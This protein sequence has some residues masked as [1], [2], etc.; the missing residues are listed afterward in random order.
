MH[1][2]CLAGAA[3]IIVLGSAPVARSAEGVSVQFNQDVLKS[4]GLD[5]RLAE[6]F[7]QAPRFREGVQAVALSVNGVPK[8]RV[9]VVFDAEGELC[10]TPSLL[11]RGGIRA[12]DYVEP[13]GKAGCE[14]FARHF[15]G[16]VVQADPSQEHISLL[17]PTDALVPDRPA[18]RS[19]LNGGT[20]G[21]FNYD[22]L[23]L[24]SRFAGQSS[25]FRNLNAELGLNAADWS[26]RSR[27]VYSEFAGQDR[28][29][30]L[31]AYAS[32]TSERYRANLQLG[33][34]NM[35]SPLFAGEAFNGVQ[36]Q[37]E[38]ALM[39]L[40]DDSSGARVEGIAYSAAR[41]EVTQNGALIYT[42]VVPG[43]PFTLVG[44]PLLSQS[45][46][47]E[48]TVH[49]EDGQQRRFIVP[50]TQLRGGMTGRAAGYGLAV[51]QVRR[52]AGDE[53]DAPSFLAASKDW[54]LGPRGQVTAGA[55]LG[56]GY[57]SLG[58]AMQGGIGD[59]LI[60][61][62]RQVISRAQDQAVSGTQLQWTASGRLSGRL[63][64]SVALTQ[65]T[66]GFRTL[67]DTTWDSRNDRP[68]Q[69]VRNQLTANLSTSSPVYGGFS[70][71]Y[72]RFSMFDGMA[73]SRVALAWSQSIRRA[74]VTF[75]VERDVAG[76]SDD[77]RG[78]AAYLS[79]SLPLGARQTLRG[80][81]RND[82]VSGTRSG[83]RFN[84][85]SSD[86]LAYSIGAERPDDGSAGFNGR[87]NLLPRYSQMD[88]GYSRSG[89]GNQ[90]YDIGLRGGA[91][92]HSDGV[93]LSPYPLRETF[94]LLKA[95]DSAGVKLNTPRGPVWTDHSGHAVAAS[96]PA[97]SKGRVELDTASLGRNVD[98]HN[99]YQEVE[100]GRAAVANMAFDMVTAR[101][102]LLQAR[103][104]DSH[105]VR[106]GVGVFDDQGRYVTS[107]LEA[108]Q[109]FLPDVQPD[110]KLHVL[111]PDGQRCHLEFAMSLEPDVDA[112]YE[113]ASAIC[114][115]V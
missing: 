42:T 89:A 57:E 86:T 73:T 101:R 98:V 102:V 63:S 106:K 99:A 85:Q 37:P 45:V 44:L 43:G 66:Q 58:W 77:A 79:V 110:L 9:Q 60:L 94:A 59:R 76:A 32:H 40:D 68:F 100:A 105:F 51:G 18:D 55:M 71:S 12:A 28:L 7:S 52:Y 69:R 103:M 88:M 113:T 3:L 14:L 30:H 25:Q 26:F 109:I 33:Q 1:W 84:E 22:A 11:E 48:V 90:N 108:G 15:R 46:D 75:T 4:R 41:I 53:R 16:A 104:P 19:F 115:T 107:V 10:F 38:L 92:V 80:Y 27:Q 62:G 21:L 74:T 13:S 65:Q 39:A 97:Y 64:T 91:L 56:T 47:L 114:R 35:V 50:A 87:V 78:T 54:Q 96:L 23:L 49:E 17:L 29:E 72:S 5:P 83:L 2:R 81:V 111:L 8:G 70:A 24:G 6:Y 31:Y 36:V 61:G 82:A 34:L 112:L 93:T 20:A 95:G 67:S